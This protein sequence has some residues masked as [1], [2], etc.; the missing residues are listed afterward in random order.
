M[1][2]IIAGSR[3]GVRYRDVELAIRESGWADDITVVISG[4]AMG[5]DTGG[6]TWAQQHGRDIE[7]FPIREMDWHAHGKAAGPIRNR[8]MAEAADALI[9][10]WDGESRG[11][12][13]MIYEARKRGLPVHV[14][15][16]GAA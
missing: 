4:G 16:L 10:V 2:V 5:V 6:E 12:R 1:R 9:A 3:S 7:R 13:N 14:L 8:R 15:D 11:T